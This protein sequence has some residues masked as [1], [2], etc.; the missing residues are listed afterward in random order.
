MI[1]GSAIPYLRGIQRLTT[2]ASCTT[3]QITM[4]SFP[5]LAALFVTHFHDLKGQEVTYYASLSN[6]MLPACR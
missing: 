6:G 5:P 4:A 2:T 3:T 1:A